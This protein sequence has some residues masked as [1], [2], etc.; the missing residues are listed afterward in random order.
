MKLIHIT[1]I[2]TVYSE[3]CFK[4][5]LVIYTEVRYLRVQMFV[6]SLWSA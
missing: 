5:F 6:I 4:M 1:S 2:D 3:I